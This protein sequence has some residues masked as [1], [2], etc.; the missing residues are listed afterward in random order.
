[1]AVIWS[2][3]WRTIPR[4]F[5]LSEQAGEIDDDEEMLA[6]VFTSFFELSKIHVAPHETTKAY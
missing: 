1:M 2:G 3:T 4:H 6:D 5:Y